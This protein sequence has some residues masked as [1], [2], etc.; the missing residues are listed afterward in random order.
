MW[1][2]EGMGTALRRTIGPSPDL[3][4]VKTGWAQVKSRN[5]E[6]EP[7]QPRNGLLVPLPSQV[8]YR[9]IRAEVDRLRDSFLT[10]PEL[11]FHHRLLY[12]SIKIQHFMWLMFASVLAQISFTY[13]YRKKNLS[14][15]LNYT[16]NNFVMS[17]LILYF[18]NDHLVD[19][20]SLSY[21][22]TKCQNCSFYKIQKTKR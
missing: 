18:T 7:S 19:S 5:I 11:V 20:L 10:S 22:W 8:G 9:S 17:M 3:D 12:V 2:W 4:S 13:S 1:Q 6:A 15:K 21:P 14:K 16:A